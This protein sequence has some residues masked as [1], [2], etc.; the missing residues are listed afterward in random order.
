MTA[1]GQMADFSVEKAP[2]HH[3]T[4]SGH[5]GLGLASLT[6]WWI[7]DEHVRMLTL[8]KKVCGIPVPAGMSLTFFY[9]V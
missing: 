3:Y 5:S 4:I 8:Q 2:F 6:T 9:S 7:T 1:Q